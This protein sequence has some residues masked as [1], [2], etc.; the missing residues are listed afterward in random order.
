MQVP[1]NVQTIFFRRAAARGSKVNSLF[2]I[3]RRPTLHIV[4]AVVGK[5]YVYGRPCRLSAMLLNYYYHTV[6]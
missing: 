5:R 1:G 3:I 2:G 6:V 4:L